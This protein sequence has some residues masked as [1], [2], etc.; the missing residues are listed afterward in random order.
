MGRSGLRV[1]VLASR[2][3]EL[4]DAHT[5]LGYFAMIPGTTQAQVAEI[6]RDEDWVDS[7]LLAS[8]SS[9]PHPSADRAHVP[10]SCVFNDLFHLA[11]ITR[12]QRGPA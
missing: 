5:N 6:L 3:R 11:A 7:F 10:L 9:P 1:G 12:R 2:N 8:A 4:L